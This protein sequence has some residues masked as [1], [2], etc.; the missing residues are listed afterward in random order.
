M[1][2][3]VGEGRYGLVVAGYLEDGF[4]RVTGF[5]V[6]DLSAL[7][8]LEMNP[9]DVVFR[10]HWMRD[11]A[12][13]DG[14]FAA[15]AV[16]RHFRYVFFLRGILR[17]RDELRHRSRAT[18]ERTAA[19]LD[20]SDDIATSLAY[21]ETFCHKKALLAKILVTITIVPIPMRTGKVFSDISYPSSA[22]L[23]TQSRR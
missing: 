11:F 1:E 23:L 6:L 10:Q 12:D 20:E 9:L 14:D 5:E 13:L 3:A 19:V 2:V 16:K 21:K 7:L 18:R 15:F 8:R 17:V 22:L 4:R